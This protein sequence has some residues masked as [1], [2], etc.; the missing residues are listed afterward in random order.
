[1]ENPNAKPSQIRKQAVSERKLMQL[2]FTAEEA[3]SIT[4]KGRILKNSYHGTKGDFVESVMDKMMEKQGYTKLESKVGSNNGYDGLYVLKD[5]QG[6][7]T[8]VVIGEAKYGTSRLR[9]TRTM[10]KQMDKQWI[11]TNW[12]K[13]GDSKTKKL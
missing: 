12:R 8:K 6:N 9:Q 7:V 1:M 11:D 13:M 3:R 5:S 2:G 10:G 4:R